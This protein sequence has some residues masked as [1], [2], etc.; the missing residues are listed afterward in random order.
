MSCAA[1]VAWRAVFFCFFFS[2]AFSQPAENGFV[3]LCSSQQP[4]TELPNEMEKKVLLCVFVYFLEYPNCAH[5]AHS[6]NKEQK[7]DVAINRRK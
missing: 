3:G 6:Q 2:K 7:M 1:L 4:K 5:S